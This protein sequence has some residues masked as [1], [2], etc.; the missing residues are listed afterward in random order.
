MSVKFSVPDIVCDGCAT[1]IKKA[2]GGIAGVSEVAVNV[3]AKEVTV[4]HN[5]DVSR[6]KLVAALDRAGFGVAE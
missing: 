6:E 3:P 5:A 4:A 1:A 2:L